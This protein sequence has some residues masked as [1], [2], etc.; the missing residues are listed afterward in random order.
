MTGGG[1]VWVY[2]RCI[3]DL[4]YDWRVGH[5]KWCLYAEVTLSFRA[6]FYSTEPDVSISPWGWECVYL[7]VLTMAGGVNFSPDIWQGRGNIPVEMYSKYEKSIGSSASYSF[8][9]SKIKYG[10][11]ESNNAVRIITLQKMYSTNK[12]K[13]RCSWIYSTKNTRLSLIHISEPTRPY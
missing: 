2:L 1:W 5:W 8:L 12:G 11:F 4:E 3:N 7:P 6:H 10:T 9:L 13:K